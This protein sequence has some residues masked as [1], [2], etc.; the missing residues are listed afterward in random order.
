MQLG[1]SSNNVAHSQR[2]FGLRIFNYAAR[3]Y[4]CL[5]LVDESLVDPWSGNPA[6]ESIFN[7]YLLWKNA[8]NGVLGEVLGYVTLSN[9]LIIDSGYSG[10]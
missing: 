2:K 4:P 8:E 7:N 6:I 1:Q 5:P 10:M 3:Q 9:F